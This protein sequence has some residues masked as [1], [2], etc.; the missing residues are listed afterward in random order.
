MIDNRKT[1]QL[2]AHV[3]GGLLRLMHVCGVEGDHRS[4]VG[5]VTWLLEKEIDERVTAG[6]WQ[7]QAEGP[8]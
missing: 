7:V 3:H 8:K 6:T 2:P 1:I 5:T 4:L